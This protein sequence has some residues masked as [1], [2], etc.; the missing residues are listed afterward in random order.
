[1]IKYPVSRP[2]FSGREEGYLREVFESG[3]LTQHHFVHR[4]ESAFAKLAGAHHA[5][6]CSNGTAALHLVLLALG[7]GPGD[8]VI[9]PDITFVATAN[10]VTYCGAKPVPVDIDR[11]T[12]TID[13][14]QVARAINSR[15]RAIITVSLYGQPGHLAQLSVLAKAH[16]LFLVIDA[17]EAHGALFQSKRLGELGDAVCYSFYGNKILTCGEGG[18]VLFNDGERAN[19]ARLFRGQGMNPGHGYYHEVVGYNYRMTEMQAAIGLGQVECAGKHFAKRHDVIDW[20]KEALGDDLRE[21]RIEVQGTL[22]FVQSA[23][24]MFVVKIA[25]R[26]KHTVD[27]ALLD[28]GIETRPVFTPI[29]ELPPYRAANASRAMQFKNSEDLWDRGLCLPTYAGL[30]KDDV[31][32]IADA[33]REAIR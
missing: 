15:T 32:F 30:S 23:D 27:L 10:A 8:E 20:Y 12:W 26:D 22:P 21:G 13:V 4:F 1:M 25:G 3:Q 19:R 6:A 14:E 5:V 16:N 24:W 28:R 9:I 2:S 17:A 31:G 33:L 11:D 29:H 7:I 18:A